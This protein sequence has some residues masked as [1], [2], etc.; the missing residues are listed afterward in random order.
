VSRAVALKKDDGTLG[1]GE[2]PLLG[3]YTMGNSLEG[4]CR[5]YILDDL[6]IKVHG[7]VLQNEC[8]GGFELGWTVGGLP[9]S[10]SSNVPSGQL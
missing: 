4:R 9:K 2:S 5:R 10:M 8:D 1:H 7:K 6:L 3:S